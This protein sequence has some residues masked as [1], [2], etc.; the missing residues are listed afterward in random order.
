MQ[1]GIKPTELL[2]LIVIPALE[3]M[4][5]NSIAAQQL[6]MGTSAQ[7]T[8]LGYWLTQNKGP[9]LGIYC[10]EPKSHFDIYE[11]Y[12]GYH[13][14]VKERVDNLCRSMNIGAR[15][16]ELISNLEYATAMARLQYWRQKERLPEAGDINAMAHYW[17]KFYNSRDGKGT[18]ADFVRRYEKYVERYVKWDS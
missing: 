18:I 16:N 6:I 2:N 10:M 1:P 9:A 7:E 17:K 11:N 15:E 8:H 5:M 14:F 13:P 3:H 12:L 4:E